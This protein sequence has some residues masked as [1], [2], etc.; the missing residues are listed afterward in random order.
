MTFERK[1]VVGLEDI[2]AICFQCN[3]CGF[4]VSLPPDSA[5]SV[6]FECENCRSEWRPTEGPTSPRS[7]ESAFITLVKS[8]RTVHKLLTEDKLGFKILLEFDDPA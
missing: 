7:A 6:P 3:S 1:I 8:L 5:Q 2:K 4:K